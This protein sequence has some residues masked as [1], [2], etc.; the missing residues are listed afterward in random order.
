[1]SISW[2]TIDFSAFLFRKAS[3]VGQ[4]LM[5]L[6]RKFAFFLDFLCSRLSYGVSEGSIPV[7]HIEDDGVVG[8][9]GDGLSGCVAS[10]DPMVPLQWVRDLGSTLPVDG[11]PGAPAPSFSIARNPR[12]LLD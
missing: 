1:M 9:T 2:F 3:V 12:A 10:F 11:L 5:S 4:M 8:E 6:F 7:V